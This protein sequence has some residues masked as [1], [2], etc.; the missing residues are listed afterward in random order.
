MSI[1]KIQRLGW[2]RDSLDHRDMK[3]STAP[4]TVAL[5]P[6][7]DLRTN[8]H[9]PPV[10]DQGHLG[11]CTA[12]AIAGAVDYERHKQGEPFITPSRLFIYYNGRVMEGDPGQDNGAEIR[13]G[14]KSVNQRGVCYE[15]QWPYDVGQFAAKPWPKCYAH[16]L[17]FKA[18]TYTSIP[19]IDNSMKLV[20]AQSM[21][22]VIGFSVFESFES[23]Q[24]AAT[25]VVPMP[26]AKDKPIGGHAVCLVGYDDSVQM[27]LARNSWG[28]GWGQAGYFQIPYGYVLDGQLADDF[29]TINLES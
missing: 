6:E 10:Y 4:V 15:S 18:L 27:F 28:S 11:S 7:V 19:Q 16:A 25:G 23:D 9:L 13:D 1:R 3:M 2:R 5:P 26:S 22:I 29:W 24:V 20:L 8:G 17:K 21:L 14:I 12:N